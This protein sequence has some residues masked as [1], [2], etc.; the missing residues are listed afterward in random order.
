MVSVS[1]RWSLLRGAAALGVAL[2]AG[3]LAQSVRPAGAVMANLAAASPRTDLPS[4]AV[5]KSASLRSGQGVGLPQPTGITPVAAELPARSECPITLDLTA[6]PGALIGLSL[7]APC[8]LGERVVIRHAGL[9]FTARTGAQGT[10]QL[11]FPALQEA[12]IVAVYMEGSAIVLGEVALPEVRV[13]RR[14]A[15]Q[16]AAPA[17][18]D[19][20]VSEGGSLFVGTSSQAPGADLKVITLGSAEVSDPLL[21]Q[22]YTL[23][24]VDTAI[25]LTVEHRITEDTCGQTLPAQI[26]TAAAG[27]A[28]TRDYPVAVPLCG[29]SGNILVLKNLAPDL[30]LAAPN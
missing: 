29:S 14:F 9:S 20:R 25:D 27:R 2:A 7:N 3:H 10:L 13:L 28:E 21:A 26:I 24:A 18:F 8:N 6:L 22:V 4:E 17:Q 23:P 5:P 1:F 30:K 11:T 16:W 15:F 12:G 19:L